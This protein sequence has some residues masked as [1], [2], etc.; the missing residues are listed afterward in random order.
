MRLILR[1]FLVKSF[2]NFDEISHG[3]RAISHTYNI[4]LTL[5]KP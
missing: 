3:G 2:A 4:Y 1:P 5:K